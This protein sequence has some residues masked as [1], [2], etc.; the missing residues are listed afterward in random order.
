[1]DSNCRATALAELNATANGLPIF[2]V[3]TSARLDDMAEM[4]VPPE[5]LF[6]MGDNRDHSADSRIP[7]DEGGV[8]LLPFGNM[9]GRADALVGS[10]DIAA[11]REPIWHWASGLRWSRFFTAVH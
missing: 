8:G 7:A 2:D 4:T 1:M 9:I 10:W 6:V 5:H 11:K 3:Q